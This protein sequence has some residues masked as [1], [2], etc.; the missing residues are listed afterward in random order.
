MKSLVLRKGYQ[1]K[2]TVRETEKAIKLVKTVFEENLSNALNL[3][4]ISAPL[5]VTSE[6]GINDNL[7]GIER[8]VNFPIKA[9]PEKHAEVVQSLA[10]WKRF[11]LNKYAFKAGEGLYTNMNALRGD[12]YVDTTHSIY[13]DQWDWEKVINREDRNECYLKETVI[14]IVGAICDTLDTVK[15]EYSQITLELKRDVTFISTQE[16]EDRWP[17]KTPKEREYLIS[18]ECGTVFI[19]KI[20]EL[21]KSGEKHDGRASDY[22]DWKLNGDIFFYDEAI[23]AALEVSSM[24][25]R[26]DAET[27]DYQLTAC[28]ND[29]RRKYK[30]HQMILNDEMVLTIGGGIGQSR[31]CMLLLQKMH[32]G[33]VQVSIWP[34]DMVEVCKEN[35]I[36]VL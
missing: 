29:D 23:D 27:L 1:S 30:Y 11:A 28:G 36:I 21:L 19:M 26:V 20:G 34:D 22:D 2:L 3:E 12:D 25:I 7:N 31:L 18:K 14:N 10:K 24:G 13:V 15:K 9:I 33:E 5:I 16:L 32:I 35:G 17:D 4:R 6:S 8:I